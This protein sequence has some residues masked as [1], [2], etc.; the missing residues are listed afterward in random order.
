M[1]FKKITYKLKCTDFSAKNCRL[2]VASIKSQ[3]KHKQAEFLKL[4]LDKPLFSYSCY[5][6]KCIE[7][8]A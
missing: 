2:F 4:V 8:N 1:T 5:T 6:S 3:V 7:T